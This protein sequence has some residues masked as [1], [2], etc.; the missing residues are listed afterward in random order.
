MAIDYTLN[1]A[2]RSTK[3]KGENHRSR[4]EGMIPGVFYNAA[5]E[6]ISIQI[7]EKELMKAYQT[8]GTTRV[9]NLDIEGEGTKPCLF[10]KVQNHPVKNR[11]LHVDFYGV[12]MAKPVTL[13]IPIK[14]VGES[15]GIKNQGGKLSVYRE[16]VTVTCLPEA[17]PHCV[18]IDITDM[19]LY[20]TVRVNELPLPE[21]VQAVY[22]DT[23]KV[24]AITSTRAAAD[25]AGEAEAA[26]A[27]A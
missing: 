21:G 7:P 15:M 14:T 12:D 19:K 23:Y 16:Q 3:G 13:S 27:Q 25:A 18:E 8:V 5:G 10:W 6:N 17:I 4:V 1:V 2:P 22:D 20:D 11:P 9:L 26:A 24:M